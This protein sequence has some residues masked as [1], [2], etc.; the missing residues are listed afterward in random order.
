M[1]DPDL[2]SKSMF[3]SLTPV[4]AALNKSIISI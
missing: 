2:I 3:C 4:K 1:Y